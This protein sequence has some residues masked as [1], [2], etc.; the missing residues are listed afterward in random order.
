MPL[1]VPV[2]A[3]SRREDTF[4]RELINQTEEFG[5]LLDGT[6]EVVVLGMVVAE[7]T[8]E[9]AELRLLDVF[10]FEDTCGP[11]DAVVDAEERRCLEA[12]FHKD[13]VTEAVERL[14]RCVREFT[15]PVVTVGDDSVLH[16]CRRVVGERHEENVLGFDVVLVDYFGVATGDGGRLHSPCA[17]VDDVDS[18]FAVDQI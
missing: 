7:S 13:V 10:I 3:I 11:R 9:L 6:E 17:G 14:D 1:A 18:L 15:H 8:D 4:R 12:V 16:L 5:W 2:P